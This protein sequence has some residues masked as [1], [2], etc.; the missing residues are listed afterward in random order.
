MLEDV[1]SKYPEESALVGRV[2]LSYGVL[3]LDLLNCVASAS[4]DF[5][6]TVKTL[7]ITKG[8]TPRIKLAREVGRKAFEEAGL[9]DEFAACIKG[10]F[11]CVGIRNK[12]AHGVWHDDNSGKL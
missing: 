11:N 9:E 1:F 5:N 6:L 3:E 12:Y 10:M 2:L 8:E 4:R 7:F